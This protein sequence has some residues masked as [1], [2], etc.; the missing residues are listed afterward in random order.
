MPF[1]CAA[2][3]PP[4]IKILEAL[5]DTELSTTDAEHITC[6]HLVTKMDSAGAET[7]TL[8][9]G[10]EGQIKV[11]VAVATLTGTIT[12][13]VTNFVSTSVAFD[14]V[15]KTWIGIFVDGLWHTLGG[16]ATVT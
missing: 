1:E 5:A 9:N 11:L 10:K 2:I 12:V 7:R 8:D 15:L 3:A 16:T 6:D 4:L 13:T 14:T